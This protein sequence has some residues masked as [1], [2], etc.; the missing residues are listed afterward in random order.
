MGDRSLLDDIL[1]SD[2]EPPPLELVKQVVTQLDRERVVV[3]RDAMVKSTLDPPDVVVPEDLLCPMLHC[4]FRDPVVNA[5]GNTYE[6]EALYKFWESTH[7]ELRDPLTNA[8]LTDASPPDS[9][10]IAA[11]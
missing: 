8:A 4:A 1:D 11:V 5:A 10:F 9:F 6:R 7:G 2:D 3:G